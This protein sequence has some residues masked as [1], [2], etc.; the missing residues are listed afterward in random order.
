MSCK[1]TDS[2]LSGYLDGELDASEM[3]TVRTHL[4]QCESCH[5]ELE[6]LRAIKGMTS[7][8]PTLELP[9]DFEERL[10]AKVFAHESAPVRRRTSLV[11][12]GGLAFCTAFLGATLWIQTHRADQIKATDQI[13][14]SSFEL[15]RDQ[16]Y[17]AGGDPLA[18][19]TVV[20]TSTHGM[21]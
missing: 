8:L 10:V 5:A 6:A 14:Q 2:R 3:R 13:A 20:M 9:E 17:A 7:S 19:N 1:W 15:D 11:L 21:R 16:A 4:A 18:G 12:A